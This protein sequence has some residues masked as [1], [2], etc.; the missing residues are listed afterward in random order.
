M[1]WFSKLI[2]MINNLYEIGK[3]LYR[4]D[5]N[6]ESEIEKIIMLFEND[7]ND[8]MWFSNLEDN[9]NSYIKIKML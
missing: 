3:I 8:T 2:Q 7:D 4:E 9:L 1:K 6:E 5:E